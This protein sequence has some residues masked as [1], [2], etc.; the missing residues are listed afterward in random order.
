MTVRVKTYLLSFYT[1]CTI[2]LLFRPACS[3]IRKS[4]WKK[5]IKKGIKIW[6]IMKELQMIIIRVCH[7]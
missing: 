7:L 4:I 2:W 6:K 3:I 5:I 1:I